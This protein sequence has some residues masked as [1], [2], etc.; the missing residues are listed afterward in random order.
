MTDGLAELE[1]QL[2]EE[3]GRMVLGPVARV[4]GEE[5]ADSLAPVVRRRAAELAGQLSD[6]D[7]AVA[8]AA[9]DTVQDLIPDHPRAWWQSPLGQ[10]VAALTDPT[11]TI[12]QAEAGRTLGL[13]RGRISQL[14][15][16]GQL[17][18]GQDGQPLL[19]SVLARLIW[20]RERWQ[21]LRPWP[22]H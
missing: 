22:G 15:Q 16:S 20:S 17:E 4:L 14:V 13:T 6:P 1:A 18:T 8:A 2:V 12:T 3:I 19:T 5:V 10:A 21:N 7:R 9:A 11:R